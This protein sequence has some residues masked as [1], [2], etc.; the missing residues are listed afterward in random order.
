MLSNVQIGIGYIVLLTTWQTL[1]TTLSHGYQ[2][3][4]EITTIIKNI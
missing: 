3:A 4:I 2:D 1:H